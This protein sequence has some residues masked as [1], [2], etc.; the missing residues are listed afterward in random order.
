M[1]KDFIIKKVKELYDLRIVSNEED[2]D[3][4][5]LGVFL[6]FTPKDY[7][8]PLTTEDVS[9]FSNFYVQDDE[10]ILED[11]EYMRGDKLPI[12]KLYGNKYDMYLDD[13]IENT[14]FT[15]VYEKTS[16]KVK[17]S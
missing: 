9:C 13:F 1:D 17:L 16:K 7:N 14:V 3:G 8:N 11:V 15:H 10:V 2:F 4:T 12:L 5:N 6:K